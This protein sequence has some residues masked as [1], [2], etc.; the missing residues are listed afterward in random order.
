M[1][2]EIYRK[3]NDYERKISN[4]EKSSKMSNSEYAKKVRDSREKIENGMSTL[5]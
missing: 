1:E 4:A 5:N 3:M 2:K